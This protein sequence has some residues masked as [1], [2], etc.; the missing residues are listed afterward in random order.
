MS[1]QYDATVEYVNSQPA[2][3]HQHKVNIGGKNSAF[4]PRNKQINRD[5]KCAFRFL[6]FLFREN[7]DKTSSSGR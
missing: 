4:E 1:E 3:P 2:P 7:S 6:K 5:R